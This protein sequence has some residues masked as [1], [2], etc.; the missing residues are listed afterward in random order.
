[1][2]KLFVLLLVVAAASVAT[3]QTSREE[4]EARPDGV[5]STM[6]TYTGTIYT[7]PEAKAPKGYT[8]FYM[9]GYLR[10]GSRYESRPKYP[11]EAVEYFRKA[12]EHNLLT[13]LGKRVAEWM[14]HHYE[15]HQKR[16]G[17]LTR[18]GYEQHRGIGGRMCERFPQIFADGKCVRSLGSM[19]MRST[20]SMVA[21]NE[22][23][24]ERNPRL[25]TDMVSSFEFADIIRPQDADSNPR[26]TIEEQVAYEKFLE[27]GISQ[28]LH[29]WS[30]TLDMDHCKRA[31]FTDPDKFFALFDV[32]PFK[33]MDNIYKRLSFAQNFGEYDRELVD[34]VFTAEERYAIY[35]H[36][37]CMWW[38]RCASAS[39]PQLANTLSESRIMFDYFV[40]NIES[41]ISGNDNKAADLL[42][43]HD[44]YLI[45]IPTIL[46]MDGLP[47][48][49]GAGNELQDNPAKA[50]EI[51]AEMW[52]GYKITPKAANAVLVLY[53]H[54]SGKGD[55]LVRA[56]LN[57][58][59]VTLPLEA[60]AP[61][62]YKWEDV[63]ALIR[64]RLD[65]VD[66]L[67]AN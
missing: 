41:A 12:A 3:A 43:G 7:A 44:Y 63:K 47:L 67:K 24:K 25:K 56:L 11:T 23:L 9:T 28:P 60:V 54:K 53:R 15:R 40:E 29:A 61:H 5:I 34:A 55:V 48:T 2:K 20:I 35:R 31:L 39:Y 36:E 42:F 51:T 10:H 8:P 37:A 64:S 19:R 57:E 50:V 46:S 45:P 18:V 49:L 66:R 62:F 21:F 14:E 52:R 22:G 33:I 13:P 17:D 65:E 27:E 58:R 16:I 38:Y 26:Y 59:D 32:V 6:T 1:M 4:I 30:N